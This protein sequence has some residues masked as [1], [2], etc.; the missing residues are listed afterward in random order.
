MEG[1]FEDWSYAAS[2]EGKFNRNV[3]PACKGISEEEMRMND[4]I[5][6]SMTYLIETSAD[7]GPIASS[8]GRWIEV[9]QPSKGIGHVSRNIR[10]VLDFIENLT[11]FYVS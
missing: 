5:A 10:L 3:F 8:Y 2:W 7:K 6:R 1:S 4:S 11:P 9:D